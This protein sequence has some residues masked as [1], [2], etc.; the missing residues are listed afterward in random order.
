MIEECGPENTE[1]QARQRHGQIAR[2]PEPLLTIQDGKPLIP[3]RC[4]GSSH[5]ATLLSIQVDTVLADRRRPRPQPDLRMTGLLLFCVN[6]KMRRE[7]KG[8]LSQR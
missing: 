3:L 2:V 8:N 1:A 5:D 6:G 4:E 7:K